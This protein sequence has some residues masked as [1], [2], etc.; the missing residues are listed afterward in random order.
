MYGNIPGSVLACV[1]RREQIKAANAKPQVSMSMED[2]FVR[3]FTSEYLLRKIASV[4]DIYFAR[5]KYRQVQNIAKNEV[6][7][8]DVL[9]NGIRLDKPDITK[10][11]GG[12]CDLFGNGAPDDSVLNA[13]NGSTYRRADGGKDSTL[14]VKV[15]GKWKPIA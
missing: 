3:D 2:V 7:N 1:V 4:T 8:M 12:I 15:A 10:P 9:T 6:K 11:D 14:Y 5:L 13:G